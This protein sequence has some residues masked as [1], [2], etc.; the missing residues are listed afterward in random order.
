MGVERDR[1]AECR[2]ALEA[3]NR[4]DAGRRRRG[5]G[6]SHGGRGLAQIGK[7]SDDRGHWS[8][9][10]CRRQPKSCW[11]GDLR[12]LDRRPRPEGQAPRL[13]EGVLRAPSVRNCIFILNGYTF[14]YEPPRARLGRTAH[15]PRSLARLE[16]QRRRAAPRTH[17][18]DSWA[19]YRR[20]RRGSRHDFVHP[21]T[22]RAYP[23]RSRERARAPCGSHGSGGGHACAVRLVGRFH[24][25]RRRQSDRE[26]DHRLRG[27]SAD[28]RRLSRPQSG[29]RHRACAHQPQPGSRPWRR[30]HCRAHDP[31]DP[32]RACRAPDRRDA[33]PALRASRLSRSLRR[34]ALPRRAQGSSPHRLR[35][36]QC[37]VS[38]R[39]RIGQVSDAGGF[40][41]SLRQR[42]RPARGAARRRRR[43]RLPGRDRP[44]HARAYPG[45]AQR[46][47]YDAR[48]LARHAPGSEDCAARA[49]SF[50]LARAELSPT[51]SGERAAPLAREAESSPRLHERAGPKRSDRIDQPSGP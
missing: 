43:R 14:S 50:R 13:K 20:A 40:R 37:D 38:L 42:S 35:P 19:A 49:P 26:R 29:N 5:G 2:R 48:S 47:P 18:A 4:L 23:H 16:P 27:A 12:L 24:R 3:Q 8:T 25:S 21:L 7:A 15:L 6:A 28:L 41:L 11:T 10:H 51:I 45:F 30:R 22:P 1:R 39:G 17:P 34:T 9:P 32:K 36:R 33:H 46:L 44:A 31:A